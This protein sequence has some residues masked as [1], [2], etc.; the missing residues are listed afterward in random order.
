MFKRCTIQMKSI[1]RLT[2][3]T[4]EIQYLIKVNTQSTVSKPRKRHQFN[5]N[6]S[7]KHKLKNQR[8]KLNK[9]KILEVLVIL[10][11]SRT[12]MPKISELFRTQPIIWIKWPV[13]PTQ[14]TK[15][16]HQTVA[17]S[18]P[19]EL[20]IA[21][22]PKRPN[23]LPNETSSTLCNPQ[24]LLAPRHQVP[25]WK[26]NWWQCRSHWA[27]TTAWG[28]EKGDRGKGIQE[29]KVNL[30]VWMAK[31]RSKCENRRACHRA[32]WRWPRAAKI[33]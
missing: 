32:S 18:I 11:Y 30:L 5:K 23:S 6:Q 14:I 3:A 21:F 2:T 25:S 24:L 27:N 26:V 13:I 19:Q 7:L 16:T 33:D 4:L 9:R 22:S 1:I 20:S 8:A 28:L 10:N 29:C 15:R 17:T 31:L 12:N